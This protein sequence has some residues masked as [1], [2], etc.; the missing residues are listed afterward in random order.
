MTINT[1]VNITFGWIFADFMSGFFHWFEDRYLS[2]D[3]YKPK[4][5]ID[6]NIFQKIILNI[7]ISNERHHALPRY[8]LKNNFFNTINTTL[9]ISIPLIIIF[10]LT[11]CLFTPFILSFI[12]FGILSNQFHK[13]SHMT[14]SELNPFIIFLQ[15]NWIILNPENHRKHHVN[16]VNT[17]CVTN[18]VCNII[19]DKIDFWNNLEKLIIKYFNIHPSDVKPLEK[20]YYFFNMKSLY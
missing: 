12:F 3:M 1:L 17:Y 20:N 8:M 19:L 13:Y 11:N 14:K 2:S 10:Y 6:L 5:T 9:Y 15:N 7:A 4:D 16:G 18:G